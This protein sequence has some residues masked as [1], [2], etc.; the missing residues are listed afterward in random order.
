MKFSTRHLTALLCAACCTLALTACEQPDWSNPDYIQKTLEEG[1]YTE[2]REAINNVDELDEEDQEKVAG[3][4]AKVYLEEDRL[5]EDAMAM[6]SQVRSADAKEAYLHEVRTDEAGYAGAAAEALGIAEVT[7]ALDEMI[8]LY[9]STDDSD[10]QQNLLRGFVHMPDPKLVA[11]L[12]ETMHLDADNN[13]I[14]LH[15]D[16]CDILGDIAAKSPDAIDEKANRAL[17]RGIFVSNN[18]GQDV[19]KECGLALQKLGDP[20]VPTLLETFRGENKEVN[21]LLRKYNQGPE[22]LFPANTAK[23]DTAVILGMMRAEQA[24]DV[25]LDDLKSEK[26][27]P[28][29]LSGKHASAWRMK[30]VQAT[31]SM[32]KAL[33]EIGSEKATE[34]L[35]DVVKGKYVTEEWDEIT[36]ALEE[37]QVRQDAGF[38]LVESGDRE[39][40]DVL[41]ET[42]K[43]GVIIDLE[44]R[45]AMIEDTDQ[46]MPIKQRYQFNWMMAQ[47]YAD[48]ADADGKEALAKLAESTEEEELAER[49]ES[50]LP[51]IEKGGA[52]LSKDKPD[53][54]AK[55]LGE[56]LGDDDQL[57]R[58]KAAYEL[59]RLPKEAA[60]P[61]VAEHLDHRDMATR[62]LI[63]LAGFNVGDESLIKRIDE[64][65]DDEKNRRGD[66]YKPIRLQLKHLQ[67]WLTNNKA[68]VAEK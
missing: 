50:F 48:L 7:A 56:L 14:R 3:A 27:A 21:T 16:A 20:A 5:K 65:L 29:Q 32:I 61:I 58:E 39:A 46:P 38:S 26:T 59:G 33:G 17:V 30:E 45:A 44:K 31:S 64:V 6:L 66:E 10:V 57:V 8:E 15:S 4:L 37:L 51:M 55:C 54:Q 43:D 1:D 28:D 11:P 60:A 35:T 34:F 41:L 63:I 2:R 52:C 23:N 62:E 9:E 49:Y 24:V 68:A 53:A 67:A 19:S 22:Y 47:A 25:F 42:A 40:A 12:T 13:P 18:K 36:A